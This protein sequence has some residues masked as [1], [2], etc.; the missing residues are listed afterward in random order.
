MSLKL[1]EKSNCLCAYHLSLSSELNFDV[2]KAAQ[3][4]HILITDGEQICFSNEITLT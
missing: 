2:I 3:F 4:S 1:G